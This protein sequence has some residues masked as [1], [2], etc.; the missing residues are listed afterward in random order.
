MSGASVMSILSNVLK[1]LGGGRAS[2]VVP[3]LCAMPVFAHAA[4]SV[5]LGAPTASPSTVAVGAVVTVGIPISYGGCKDETITVQD[6][7]PSLLTY[8]SCSASNSDWN[9]N[10]VITTAG[11]TSSSFTPGNNGNKSTTFTF[12]YTAT[13]PGTTNVTLKDNISASTGITGDIVIAAAGGPDHYE[14]SLPTN[15]ISCLPTSVIVTACA[16]GSSPCTSAYTAVNGKTATLAT[17]AGSLGTSTVAFNSAGVA[18]STLAYPAAADGASVS[19]T[20]FG[21]QVAATNARKCCPDGASC[22]AANSCSTVFKTAGFI[23]AGT[24]NGAAMTI[25]AQ[26]AGTSSNTYYL[27]AVKTNSATKA[28]E[29]ALSGATTVNMGYECINPTTCYT[30]DLMSV[31]GGVSTTISRNNSNSVNNYSPVSMI[32]DGNGNAPFAFNY[33]DAGQV[34]LYVSKPAGGLLLTSL[35][36]ASNAFVT[37]PSS[38]S[39]TASCDGTGT[40]NAA[41]QTVPSVADPKFCQAGKPFSASVKALTS[42]GGVAPNYG[43][44]NTPKTVA[45]SWGRYLPSIEGADGSLPSGVFA[46]SGGYSGT[47]TASNLNWSEV[48]ILSATLTV[49]DGDYL[50]AGNVVSTAYVGRFYPDH[51]DVVVTPQCGG[52]IYAGRSEIPV[53]T[54]QPFTVK[55]TAMN[56]LPTPSVTTNYNSSAGFSKTV[57]LSLSAGGVV[58]KLYVDSVPGGTGALPAIKFSSGVGTVNHNDAVGKISYVFNTFPS[59][60]AT[61]AVHADDIDSAIS[62]GNDGSTSARAGRLQLGNAYGSEFLDLPIPLGAQYWANGGYYVANSDDSCTG[63]NVSSI[64][65]SNF[66]QNLASCETQLSPTGAQTLVGGKLNLRLLKPGAGNFGSVNLALNIGSSATGSTC[67][68]GASSAATAANLPWFGGANPTGHATFGIYKTPLIYRRENY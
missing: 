63:F 19:V 66:T 56:G 49:G 17:S 59:V 15:G 9:C 39:F 38:F 18:T 57:D 34:K 42:G 7:A 51:F 1:F 61:I 16:N 36:G 50:G 13:S 45:A 5:T 47:F 10:A 55:V 25:P 35:T 28:C 27:R 41:S 31:S 43:R 33:G 23:F 52:F 65:L 22:V 4:C 30:S 67:V 26:V 21:E 37:K 3:L 48:G 14:L 68:S 64:I 8:A 2:F 40:T 12:Y 24:A 20:L 44:E 46:F 60:P 11:V 29:A 62:N 32:F 54:G 6:N 53:L 58:G